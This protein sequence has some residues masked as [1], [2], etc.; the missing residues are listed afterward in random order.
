MKKLNILVIMGLF[1]LLPFFKVAA[2]MVPFVIP[3]DIHP[4]SEIAMTFHP[5]ESKDRLCAKSH[6]YNQSGQ[7]IRLWGV[8]LSFAANFPTHEDS[9]R[10]V[11]RLAAAGV[12]SVRCHHMDT[13]NWP[14]G[15]WDKNGKD[16][17]PEAL[18]R[19]DFLI[20][21]LAKH[22]IYTNINL[23]V[24]KK[25]SIDL[26]IPESGREFD[27]VVDL[28]TPQ[29]MEAQKE[30][31]CRLLTRRNKYR[32]NMTYAEDYAV[33][34]VEISNED[35]VFMSDGNENNLSNWN[36]EHTLRN[37]PPFY[38]QLLQEQYNV[39]LMKKYSTVDNLK[40]AWLPDSGAPCGTMSSESLKEGNIQ[41][42]AESESTHRKVDRMVFLAETEK[43]YYDEMK[44]FLTDEL[45]CKA[46][47]TGTIVFSP[48]SLYTQSNMDFIDSHAYWQHP[49]FPN[50]D[51]D[52]A[53]WFINQKPMSYRPQESVL[54][55]LAAQR[56][57][58]K[59][60]TVTEYNHSAPLDS[61]AECVPMIASFAAAQDWDGLWL[62][63]YSHENDQ[64]G[65]KH[66]SNFFDI[67]TNP[68]KWGFMQAG[69]AIFRDVGLKP[70]AEQTLAALTTSEAN[71]TES[72]VRVHWEIEQ[73]ML[74]FFGPIYPYMVSTAFY[75]APY[76]PKKIR[77]RPTEVNPA[78]KANL[79][80]SALG[81]EGLYL[82]RNDQ[83]RIMAGSAKWF[84]SVVEDVFVKI[85]H[86]GF[87]VMTITSLD[88][89]PIGSST[90]I[91][92]TACGRCENTDMKFS[93]DR[94][95]I[96]NH[97]GRAPVLIEPV[98]GSVK[99]PSS[100]TG[101]TMTCKILKPDG[102]IREQFA[103]ME[104]VLR[105]KPEYGTMWYLVERKKK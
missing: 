99:L 62:Y 60:F 52:E 37:L 89:K 2:E 92:I 54:P 40:K 10:L 93:E 14:Y 72:L 17:H 81:D 12:N 76:H 25:F 1:P 3:A 11:K 61:Q 29:L 4:E 38:A 36:A 41:V 21:Q 15:I 95:T 34:I 47:I 96:G 9:R 58:G 77:Q 102:T 31:A 44:R 105:L 53:D 6:F 42:F 45:N 66:L 23:H 97:W 46:M 19:L 51:W 98:E 56:M 84:Q 35:S 43:T 68:S 8:N 32:E 100:I 85:D 48:M 101:H 82:V 70:F 59:P 16:F 55:R 49:K 67:D 20:D 86:P 13:R 5:L 87:I 79:T 57:E 39:W 75:H 50:R 7:R 33:A 71:I 80:W 94:R 88:G 65:R 22:G 63:T 104:N 91:L 103:V 74:A 26:D 90:K 78:E 28:F 83:C 18:D 73:N 30:Y 69:A 27:K 64:W 24:G